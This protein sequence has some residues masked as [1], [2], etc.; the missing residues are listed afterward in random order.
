[1]K[2][3]PIL[4]PAVPESVVE[5]YDKDVTQYI[6]HINNFII[7]EKKVAAIPFSLHHKN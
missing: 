3:N 7:E 6:Q 5:I 4:C 2:K 1:M